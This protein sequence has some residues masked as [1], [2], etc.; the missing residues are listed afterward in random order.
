MIVAGYLAV[1][2]G[3]QSA[4]FTPAQMVELML[5]NAGKGLIQD[6][7]GSPNTLLYSPP[8]TDE[9]K[10]S[11]TGTASLTD[12]VKKKVGAI[13]GEAEAGWA[14]FVNQWELRHFD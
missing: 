14:K 1:E 6:A 9:A 3:R 13:K 11:R 8:P 10:K 7:Q 4:E 5:F 2:A 12:Q